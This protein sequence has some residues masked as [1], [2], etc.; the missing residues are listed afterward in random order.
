MSYCVL[1][2]GLTSEPTHLHHPTHTQ[3]TQDPL[4]GHTLVI[5][6]VPVTHTPLI[7]KSRVLCLLSGIYLSISNS[8]N[9]PFVFL[10]PLRTLLSHHPLRVL[11]QRSINTF[12]NRFVH[13]PAPRRPHSQICDSA[14]FIEE[15]GSVSLS[16][17][18]HPNTKCMKALLWFDAQRLPC[19]SQWGPNNSHI[20]KGIIKAC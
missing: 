4:T 8:L 7:G 15:A 16:S 2:S 14:G 11:H 19:D 5:S 3:V 6:T 20:I 18:H 17:I 9:I 10:Q 13:R 12:P 1:C